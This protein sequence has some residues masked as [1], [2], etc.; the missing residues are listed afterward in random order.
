MVQ[1]IAPIETIDLDGID[2]AK[3]GV[4]AFRVISGDR[5]IREW[6]SRG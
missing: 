4:I 5:V 3:F 6:R 1:A 2:M